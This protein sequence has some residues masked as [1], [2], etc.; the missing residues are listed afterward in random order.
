MFLLATTLGRNHQP[1][2]G[3]LERVHSEEGVLLLRNRYQFL[4]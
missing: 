2:L 4:L 3:L 1:R